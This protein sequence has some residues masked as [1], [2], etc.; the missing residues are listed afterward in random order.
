M[1]PPKYKLEK[2]I[3]T[4]TL[5]FWIMSSDVNQKLKVLATTGLGANGVCIDSGL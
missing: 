3:D 1:E 2:S 4:I 5:H